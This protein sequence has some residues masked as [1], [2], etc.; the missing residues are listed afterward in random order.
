MQVCRIVINNF[1]SLCESQQPI[2]ATSKKIEM[3][4][5]LK[6]ASGGLV[7]A[8]A[9]LW[10]LGV[11]LLC[12]FLL[13]AKI[14]GLP[15]NICNLIQAERNWFFLQRKRVHRNGK[16]ENMQLFLSLVEK[17]K[18]SQY[19]VD[20]SYFVVSIKQKQ[21]QEYLS[22]TFFKKRETQ[23]E[24]QKKRGYINRGL[25]VQ[26]NCKLHRFCSTHAPAQVGA[27]GQVMTLLALLVQA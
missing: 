11:G 7:L 20:K 12:I 5:R 27:K 17:A 10:L 16:C 2:D 14:N 6:R 13:R 22:S 25:R 1:L 15:Q 4:Q 8:F 3:K 21:M 23:T 19:I 26:P 18:F 24:L 9:L